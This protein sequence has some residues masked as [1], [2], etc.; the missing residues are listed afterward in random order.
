MYMDEIFLDFFNSKV[1]HKK[2]KNS[3]LKRNLSLSEVSEK[4][5][6]PFTTLKR[7]EEGNTDKIPFEAI[8]K[9]SAIYGTDYNSYY[10]WTAFPLFGSLSGLLISLFYGI[11]IPV[12]YTGTILGSIFGILG[13]VTGKKIFE[14]TSLKKD[15]IKDIIYNSLTTE[16]QKEYDDFFLISKTLLKTDNILAN[17]EKEEMD[18]LL[19]TT[20]MMHQI[21]K[22]NK[23]KIINFEEAEIL[24]DKD[25]N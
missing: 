12:A 14:K 19:F 17:D 11:S 23:K 1:N 8:K 21:R 20:F 9:L 7:Y 6:I 24:I 22:K 13:M 15:N 18:K 4:S 10:V 5:G 2:L 25:D 3:R 16:E